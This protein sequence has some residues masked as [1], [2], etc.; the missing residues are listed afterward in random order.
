MVD[1]ATGRGRNASFGKGDEQDVSVVF[2]PKG[3]L[4]NEGGA[5]YLMPEGLRTSNLPRYPW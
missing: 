2:E 5:S 1:V 3:M 4:L